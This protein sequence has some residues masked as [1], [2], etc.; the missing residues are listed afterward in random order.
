MNITHL[1]SH[2]ADPG[3]VFNAP[4][5]AH[6]ESAANCHLR[7]FEQERCYLP[8]SRW[9]S[10]PGGFFM[11]C[12]NAAMGKRFQF[13]MRRMM[14]AVALSCISVRLFYIYHRNPEETVL[15]YFGFCA[16]VGATAGVFARHPVVFAFLGIVLGFL[17]GA[18]WSLPPVVV[19]RE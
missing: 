18:L 16:A 13:S 1:K 10:K 2:P 6:N 5:G 4:M 15:A 7:R 3:G 9:A 12:Y 17:I 19:I 11:R 8:Q 14:V